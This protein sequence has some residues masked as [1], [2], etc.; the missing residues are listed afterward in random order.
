[1]KTEVRTTAVSY[2]ISIWPEDCSC[3]DSMT[4]CCSVV[5]NGFGKWS[6]RRGQAD[7][8]DEGRPCLGS[9]GLWHYENLPS[10]RT[11]EELERD[12]FDVVTALA[13]AREMAPRVEL[14]GLTATEAL[15]RHKHGPWCREP[16]RAS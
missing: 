16:Y 13:K 8:K 10:D 12:R 4:W 15:A 9:D 7:V 3:I 14:N 6:V 5:Y 2:V 11:S 1:M